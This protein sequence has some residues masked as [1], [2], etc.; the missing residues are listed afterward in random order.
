MGQIVPPLPVLPLVAVTSRYDQALTWARQ[1]LERQ[2]GPLQFISPAFRF[3]QTDYYRDSMGDDLKKQFVA[4]SRLMDPAGISELKV[5]TNQYEELYRTSEACGPEAR[6]LNLDPGYLSQDKLVLA[7]TKN[8]AHRLYLSQGIYAEITL[9]YRAKRWQTCPWTY[10]DYHQAA[11]HDFFDQ[12]REYL[13]QQL[14]DIPPHE[15]A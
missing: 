3:D 10:P 5:A 9:Q 4:A 13:R 8:H 7:S 6:P 11:Y 15:L 12:A 2:L 14:R 1:Q